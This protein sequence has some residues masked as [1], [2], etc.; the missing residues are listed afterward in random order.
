MPNSKHR[1]RQV[2]AN[3]RQVEK[4]R[5]KPIL[6]QEREKENDS[7]GPRNLQNKA[8]AASPVLET[9]EQN[10]V[11]GEGSSW[12]TTV[13]SLYSWCHTGIVQVRSGSLQ[14]LRHI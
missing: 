5:K 3:R 9:R 11:V 4:A 6:Q 14:C 13:G 10:V 2:A 7:P 8:K 12:M 1:K